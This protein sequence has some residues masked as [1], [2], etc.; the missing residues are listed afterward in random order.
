MKNA[1]TNVGV[2]ADKKSVR[3]TPSGVFKAGPKSWFCIPDMKV[4][5]RNQQTDEP[6]KFA[7]HRFGL[8]LREVSGAFGDLG[9]FLPHI[10]GAITLVGLAPVGILISF[11]LFYIVS[12]VFYGLPMAIQPMKAASAAMLVQ[13]MDA[14]AVAGA[15][16]VIGCFFLVIGATGLVDRLARVIPASVAAGLQLGLGFSLAVLGIK[17]F[18]SLPWLGIGASA[19]VLILLRN[20][21]LPAALVVLGLGVAVGQIAGLAPPIGEIRFGL[22]F[23]SFSL[24]TWGQ[25]LQGTK[26]AVLPQIPLTI[27]NAIIV[28]AAVVKGL[29]PREVHPVNVRNLSITTGIGN[30]IASLFGGYP[31]CHG[32]G[33]VTAHHRFGAR[34]ATAPLIIGGLLI[35][36]GVLL[37]DSAIEVL[38]AIPESVL[39]SLLLF[40]GIDLAQ[41]CRPE[42]FN[43]ADL[44]LVLLLAAICVALSPAIAFAIGLP[45]SWAVQRGWLQL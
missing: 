37:G 12:G 43:K 5:C 21:R 6:P 31:M 27:T 19:L 45:V 36:L 3:R 15:G 34:T 33:G 17:M 38:R 23:P 20:R 2:P 41:S 11:G 16:L 8:D 44:L 13:T 29:Y 28:T 42:R 9:T 22:H 30:I 24:P 10:I 26:D 35:I 25:I 4:R 14:G 18:A 39:G 32:A 7:R 1:A 40:S